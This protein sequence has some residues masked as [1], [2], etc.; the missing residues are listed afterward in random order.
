MIATSE[1]PAKLRELNAVGLRRPVVEHI[2]FTR[3]VAEPF[4]IFPTYPVPPVLLISTPD[5]NNIFYAKE[6]R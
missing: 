2:S 5:F 3:P 1:L 6:Q 4:L